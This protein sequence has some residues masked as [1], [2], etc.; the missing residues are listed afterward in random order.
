MDYGKI[1]LDEMKKGCKY[2]KEQDAYV[3]NHCGQIFHAG[4]VLQMDDSFFIAESAVRKHIRQIHGSNL[5]QLLCSESKYNTLT[6]NQRDLLA[7]FYSKMPDKDMAKKLNVTE[8]T[9]RRQ[10]FTFREKAK[11]AKFY[12]AM[13]EMAFEDEPADAEQMIPIHNHAAYVDDRYLI[14]EDEKQQIVETFF[15]S[16]QPLVLKSFSPKEKKKVVILGKIAEQFVYGKKYS[17]REV[18]EILRP[19][20]EDYMTIRRY[21]I[22]YGFMERTKDGRQYWLTN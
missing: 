12:L 16:T 15:S 1:T 18:N 14:T 9:I 20:Y 5:E 8:A 3:C 6:R 17:E 21:L 11:Q 22:M 2:E 7:M 19:V 10:R 13:Y 4:Q